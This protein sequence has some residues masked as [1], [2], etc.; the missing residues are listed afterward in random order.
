MARLALLLSSL[1]FRI[2]SSLLCETIKFKGTQKRT[3][4]I[5][6]VPG[7]RLLINEQKR[8]VTD[9]ASGW[10]TFLWWIFAVLLALVFGSSS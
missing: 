8:S 1:T 2:S 7:V 5:A 6:Y 4:W 10:F 9:E 3:W